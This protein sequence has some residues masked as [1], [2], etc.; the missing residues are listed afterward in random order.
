VSVPNGTE[1]HRPTRDVDFLGFGESSLVTCVGLSSRMTACYFS[2]TVLRVELIRDAT[3]YGGVRVTLLGY[4]AGARIPVQADIG[5]GDV[6]TPEPVQIGYPTLL[7]YPASSLPAYPLKNE[8][9]L[10]KPV[11]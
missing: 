3:E 7:E 2:L 5:C 10:Q 11:R 1:T 4:L 8:E 6:V 9:A